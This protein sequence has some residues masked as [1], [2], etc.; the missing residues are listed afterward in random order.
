MR[1]GIFADIHSNIEALD[2]VIQAYKQ[3]TIDTYLC[4]GDVVGYATAPGACI[5]KVRMLAKISVAGNHD[6]ASVDLLS[7][8]YFNDFAREAIVWTKQNLDSQGKSFLKSLELA[9]R[10]EDLT[11]VHGTLHV[12]E[13]FNYMVDG[14]IAAQT[15]KLLETDLCF[16]GHSHVAG[17]FIQDTLGRVSYY[18]G[19]TL[20][21]K[22]GN[23]YIINAGSVGQP[24][25]S[26]P[27]A[28]YCLYDTEKKSVQIK[29]V[30]YDVDS[31]RKKIIKAGLPRFLGDRLLVGR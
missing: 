1:Y 4:L 16:I 22:K 13:D 25:D 8:D 2:A 3:E 30:K 12:P 7:A 15:F 23:R 21:I 17:F 19:E 11:L 27:C 31:T 28:S 14:Y 5:E 26:N 29:R 20:D 9:Y 6:W 24:R 18:E 10:N